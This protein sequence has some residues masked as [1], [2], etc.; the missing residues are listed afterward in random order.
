MLSQLTTYCSWNLPVLNTF[1]VKLNSFELLSS[2][3]FVSCLLLTFEFEYSTFSTI[4]FIFRR[5]VS[6]TYSTT[7]LSDFNKYCILNLR[8]YIVHISFTNHWHSFRFFCLTLSECTVLAPW[9][10][11]TAKVISLTEAFNYVWLNG[12]CL[13]SRMTS[14]LNNRTIR[15]LSG[16]DGNTTWYLLNAPPSACI[17]MRTP[18]TLAEASKQSVCQCVFSL[19]LVSSIHLKL[20]CM[21]CLHLR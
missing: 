10:I 13:A 4:S 18:H 2:A 14:R 17:H 15:A 9:S 12:S 8:F 20:V 19:L 3:G 1:E 7:N 11:Q 5:C 16:A 6:D 21:F